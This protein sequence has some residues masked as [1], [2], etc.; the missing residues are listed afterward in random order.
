MTL[1]F[2]TLKYTA[3]ICLNPIC[4]KSQKDHIFPSSCPIFDYVK[5]NIKSLSGSR[6]LCGHQKSRHIPSEFSVYGQQLKKQ[7]A[8]TNFRPFFRY[9]INM[10]E[11][12]DGI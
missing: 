8:K 12:I 11:N 2:H 4:Y 10:P 3:P 1:I 6:F 9:S 7:N 5:W